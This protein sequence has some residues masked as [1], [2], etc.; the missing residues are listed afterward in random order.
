MMMIKPIVITAFI[1]LSS[2]LYGQTQEKNN[3]NSQFDSETLSNLYLNNAEKMLATEGKLKIGGYG[4]VHYNQ[5]LH[6]SVKQ[7]GTLDVHRFIMMMG[8]QFN[9]RTQFVA[10]VEYEH[11]DEVYIEQAFLQYKIN[12]AINFRAGLL[13]TPMGIINEYHEPTTFNGVERPALDHDIAPATWREI[14]L[15]FMGYILPASVKYQVYMMN[16]FSSYD[17]GPELGGSS[18]LRGG[19]QKGASSFVSSPNFTG[20]IEYFGIRG[21]NLGFSGYFGE[22]QSS[23]YDGL[24]KADNSAMAV[25]DSSVVDVTM[26]GLDA[27]YSIEGF[28]L[29][30]QY[31]YTDIGNTQ[32]YNNF[33]QSDLGEALTGYYAEAGYNVFKNAASIHSELIPFIRYEYIDTHHQVASGI[34]KNQAYERSIITAG[35][36]WKITPGAVLKADMQFAKAANADEYTQQFNAGFGIMF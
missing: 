6:S 1:L 19:R 12:N 11:V 3:T 13:L 22:T 27:R 33:T 18:A 31:Y 32:A 30:G 9:H 24:E 14:G 21:L 29:R 23:L 5:P 20:K 15:G 34:E 35:L 7:N 28:Q 8:Y 10:E 26:I 16:G 25:A 36:G 4:G 17:D 2:L